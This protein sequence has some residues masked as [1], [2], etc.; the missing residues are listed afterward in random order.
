M[1]FY[2]LLTTTLLVVTPGIAEA[3]QP[4][5]LA[6]ATAR[7]LERNHA[8]RIERDRVT[9]AEARQLGADGSYDL[10]FTADIGWRHHQD[11]VTSLFSGAPLG[12]KA[13]TR[14]D[15]SSRVGVSQLFKSGAVASLTGSVERQSTD[16]VL[17][18]LTPTYITS[19]G[20]EAR[21]PLFRG[22]GIDNARLTLRITALDHERSSAALLRQVQNTVSDVEAAYWTLV[23]ARRDVVVRR[24]SVDLADAQRAD[25]AARIEARTLAA[26]DLAQ[27]RLEVERRR[28]DLLVAEE[29]ALRAER[30]L[31]LLLADG[32]GDPLWDVALAAADA[33]DA[34]P[35]PVSLAGALADAMR[36]RPELAERRAQVAAEEAKVAF[37]R[38]N[39]KPRLDAYA[40]VALRELA[41]DR[42]DDII[43]LPGLVP[44]LPNGLYPDASA[45]VVFDVPVGRGAAR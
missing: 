26:A 8:I 7:A 16:S 43:S 23:A 22:R 35:V 40:S 4:L 9:A 44:T 29:K 24:A 31:K 42:H 13:A 38:D 11:P 30:A 33:P 39:V 25:T 27:P 14:T 36:Y 5:T 10:Q 19:V 41:G 12:A 45:G 3:Q 34:T 21:Q 37:A 17:T 2:R 1:S 32:P 15:F 20:V 28:G 6:E 18:I